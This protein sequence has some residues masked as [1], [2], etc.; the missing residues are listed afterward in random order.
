MNQFIP[1]IWIYYCHMQVG[2]VRLCIKHIIIMNLVCTKSGFQIRK[3]L[4]HHSHLSLAFIETTTKIYHWK[5]CV[6]SVGQ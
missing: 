3:L 4:V 6:C 2:F 1:Y 5:L